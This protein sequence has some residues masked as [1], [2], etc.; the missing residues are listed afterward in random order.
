MLH[1][2]VADS[3]IKK[4]FTFLSAVLKNVNFFCHIETL[5]MVMLRSKELFVVDTNLF[6][7]DDLLTFFFISSSKEFKTF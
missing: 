4:T 6:F 5:S 1:L 3:E 7:D 2:C